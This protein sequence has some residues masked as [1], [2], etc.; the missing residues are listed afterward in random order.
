MTG[1]SMTPAEAAALL[2][3]PVDA[4]LEQVERAFRYQAQ[5][6]HPDRMASATPAELAA[7]AARFDRF[8]LARAVLREADDE[9]RRRS[10]SGGTSGGTDAATPGPT[11]ARNRPPR[12]GGASARSGRAAAGET[13]AAPVWA[14]DEPYQPAVPAGPWLFW[15]WLGL[16]LVAAG[17]SFIGGPLPYSMLDLWL[18][19]IPLGL[20]AVAYAR[21]GRPGFLAVVVALGGAT[22]ALTIVYASFGPLV[23]MILLGAPV[24]G[25]VALGRYRRA[26]GR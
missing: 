20:A 16:Y 1:R 7:A 2:E 19:L 23:A 9:R 24:L 18:R 11:D 6:S 15:V 21:T 5:R 3:V 22:A 13:W 4:E 26:T 25:L 8:T 12:P 17:I 10:P 14:A